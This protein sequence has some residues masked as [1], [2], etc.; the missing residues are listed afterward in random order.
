MLSDTG[1]HR[2]QALAARF[3]DPGSS[4]SVADAL[5]KRAQGVPWR[6]A[7][8]AT[9]TAEGGHRLHQHVARLLEA[10]RAAF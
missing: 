5:L 8:V 9:L 3:F 4:K 6:P 1:I 7:A 2:E 10:A